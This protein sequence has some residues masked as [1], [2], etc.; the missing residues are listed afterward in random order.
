MKTRKIIRANLTR[1]FWTFARPLEFFDEGSFAYDTSIVDRRVLL[2]TRLIRDDNIAPTVPRC[3]VADFCV[4]MTRNLVDADNYAYKLFKNLFYRFSSNYDFNKLLAKREIEEFK[5]E[6]EIL[7]LNVSFNT[8][9]KKKLYNGDRAEF[10][11]AQK[12]VANVIRNFKNDKQY[13][14][15]VEFQVVNYN[16]LYGLM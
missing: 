12:R 9:F 7:N 6:H 16:R 15:A 10:K 5:K 14:E 13:D 2:L 8:S 3:R 4:F 1:I 11:A